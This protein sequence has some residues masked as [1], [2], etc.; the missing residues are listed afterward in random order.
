ML[1]DF[2]HVSKKYGRVQAL[3]GITLKIAPGQI[4]VVLGANGAGKTTLLRCLASVVAPSQ[5]RILADGQPLRRDRLDL[6][7]GIMFIPDFPAF[8]PHMNPL[9]H[10]AMVL[11][12]YGKDQPDVGERAILVLSKFDLLPLI[13]TQLGSLSRGQAYKVALAA[14][15]LADPGLWLLDEPLASG[16]DPAGISYLKQECREAAA[17]GRTVVYSTQLLDIAEKF[18]D[19]VCILHRGAIKFFDSVAEIRKQSEQPHSSLEDILGR[20]REVEV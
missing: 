19:R 7:R 2:D 14:L 10:I 13:E 15:F 12:L 3:D 17:R 9:Q 5:G 4:V 6:R 20:L 11:R 18:S 8:Y 1:I 16:V